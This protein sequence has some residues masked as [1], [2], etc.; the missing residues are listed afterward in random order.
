[1]IALVR[2]IFEFFK[3][4]RVLLHRYERTHPHFLWYVLIDAV[5]TISLVF[6]GF[7]FVR[8]WG[9]PSQAQI[10]IEDAGG[11]ALSADRLFGHF[12]GERRIAYWLGPIAGDL[13]TANGVLKDLVTITYLTNGAAGLSNA[14]SPNLTIQTYDSEAVFEAHGQGLVH[15]DRTLTWNSRGDE[16]I[17]DVHFMDSVIVKLKNAV[18]VVQINYPNERS[19]SSMLKDSLALRRVW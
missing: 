12:K 1:M 3:K 18:Q 14:A 9:G 7:A 15:A 17:Y 8:T 10:E 16:V 13:Y 5:I 4:E 11:V 2:F 19:A 6:G